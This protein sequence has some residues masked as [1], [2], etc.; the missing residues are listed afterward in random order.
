V[1]DS[2]KGVAAQ[3]ES[4]Y[5]CLD[6]VP[7]TQPYPDPVPVRLGPGS[8][9]MPVLLEVRGQLEGI[10]SLLPQ[11]RPRFELRLPGWSQASYPLSHLISSIDRS[12]QVKACPLVLE[13]CFLA[14]Y[15]VQCSSHTF[16]KC[17]N[18]AFSDHRLRDPLRQIQ[19][20]LLCS[21][22]Y[23]GHSDALCN[24]VKSLSFCWNFS[25]LFF[26]LLLFW[27]TYFFVVVLRFIF[28]YYI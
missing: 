5:K 14:D 25:D 12:L 11:W 26:L 17:L 10:D 24:K 6:S 15:G 9:I 28:Y 21:V 3:T 8:T 7:S 2:P 1:K 19:M 4:H 27:Y 13:P 22:R 18:C 23:F 20:V 16:L